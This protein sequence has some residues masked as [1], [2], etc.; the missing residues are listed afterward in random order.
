V[1]RRV[2]WGAAL[3]AVAFSAAY[4]DVAGRFRA[5]R[6]MLERVVVSYD[7]LLRKKLLEIPAADGAPAFWIGRAEVACVE[8]E[9]FLNEA[10]PLDFDPARQF[11][12]VDTKW[13]ASLRRDPVAFVS[14]ADAERY[15]RWLAARTGVRVRLPTRAEWERAARGGIAG[16]PYPWGWGDPAG[17]ARFDAKSPLPV[18]AAPPFG[19]GLVHMAGNVAEWLAG[20]A[21]ATTRLA[22]GGSWSE[23]R[24]E[25][26]LITNPVALP[27]GYRGADV[28]FRIAAD[29]P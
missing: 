3:F 14:S 8:F 15:C 10:G 5:R 2:L 29:P 26:L 28:G 12:K 6:A 18:G 1:V 27:A 11:R 25:L 17:R 21:A 9:G 20:D 23:R 7:P 22:A 4:F 13:R 16:A 24:P 19:Y